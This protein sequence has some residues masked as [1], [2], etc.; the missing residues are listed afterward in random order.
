MLMDSLNEHATCTWSGSCTENDKSLLWNSQWS[1]V[2]VRAW[3]SLCNFFGSPSARFPKE[4]PPTC[5]RVALSCESKYEKHCVL[6]FRHASNHNCGSTP[7]LQR[8]PIILTCGVRGSAVFA[9][10]RLPR[11]AREASQQKTPQARGNINGRAC[12]TS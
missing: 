10:W 5:P 11:L 4:N 1:V 3:C 6:I 7:T 2:G 12:P 9:A 8:L